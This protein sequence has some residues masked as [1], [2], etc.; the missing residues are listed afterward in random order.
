MSDF[1][2]APNSLA[3]LLGITLPY[4]QPMPFPFLSTAK[5]TIFFLSFFLPTPSSRPPTTVS[6]TSAFFDLVVAATF[7]GLHDL[8]FKQPA[9]FLP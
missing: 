6:S 4:N 5:T 3:L 1:I 7:H 9:R 2:N 8:A